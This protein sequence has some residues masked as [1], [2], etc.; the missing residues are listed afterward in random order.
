MLYILKS[1]DLISMI[2][3]CKLSDEISLGWK[4]ERL[5]WNE[6]PYS[7]NFSSKETFFFSDL[8]DQID[9]LGFSTYSYDDKISECHQ[10][11]CPTLPV[12]CGEGTPKVVE[13]HGITIYVFFK[14]WIMPELCTSFPCVGVVSRIIWIKFFCA[15][16]IWP[17]PYY[18][19]L[20]GFFGFLLPRLYPWVWRTGT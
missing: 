3:M 10:G 16:F 11:L 6:H 14:Y 18:L 17:D 20:V 7:Q 5:G 2:S 8:L 13:V 12:G 15:R 1:V 19:A 4:L 9:F